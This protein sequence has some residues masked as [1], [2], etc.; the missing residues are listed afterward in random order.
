MINVDGVI[1][2]NYRAS[3]SGKDLNRTWLNP[4]KKYHPEVYFL[5]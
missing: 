3:L 4:S 1:H 5:K 2:G